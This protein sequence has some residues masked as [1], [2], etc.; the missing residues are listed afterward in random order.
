MIQ[1]SLCHLV[2]LNKKGRIYFSFFSLQA[3]INKFESSGIYLR[4]MTGT[5]ECYRQY[6]IHFKSTFPY[7]PG[8]IFNEGAINMGIINGTSDQACD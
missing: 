4:K 6:I 5:W 3:M 2:S 7:V 1:D 8:P